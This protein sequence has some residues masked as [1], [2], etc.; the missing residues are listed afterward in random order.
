[1]SV[2]FQ[3]DTIRTSTTGVRPENLV[4]QN[5]APRNLGPQGLPPQ[6]QQAQ[7]QA[8]AHGLV[9]EIG[10]RLTGGDT[11]TGYLAVCRI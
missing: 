3:Q 5:L 7:A 4:P 6:G 8:Q 11:P 1:M 2:K 9:H 10:E